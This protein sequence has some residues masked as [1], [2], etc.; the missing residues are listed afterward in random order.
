[1]PAEVEKGR[2]GEGESAEKVRWTKRK[3]IIIG[4]KNIRKIQRF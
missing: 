2:A 3:T 4:R 1:M